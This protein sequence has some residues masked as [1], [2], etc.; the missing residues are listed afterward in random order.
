MDI[1]QEVLNEW[2]NSKDQAIRWRAKEIQDR[3]A[4]I[5][6]AMILAEV[7]GDS[8]K[9]KCKK[10]GISK[11]TFHYLKRGVNRPETRLARKLAK[12]TP[13][14]VAEIRGRSDLASASPAAARASRR[15]QRYSND[16][17]A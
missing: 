1:Q 12:L 4:A 17:S 9:A 11:Q 3:L 13:Y 14:T 7:P 6:M 10:I 15:I 2:L 5:P 8:I 16:L